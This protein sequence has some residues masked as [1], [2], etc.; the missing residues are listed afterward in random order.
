MFELSSRSP[1]ILVVD[2]FYSDPD[3]VRRDA[4]SREFAANN[5][6]YKGKRST[7]RLL[8]DTQK[9]EFERLLQRRITEWE[10]HSANGCFQVTN[11]DDPLVY[12]CDTQNCAAAIYLTPDAPVGAGTSFWRDRKY[13][14]RRGIDYDAET[15]REVW[16]DYNLL[17]AD[18][19]ELVDRVGAVFNRLVIWDARLIHSASSYETFGD[20]AAKSRLVQLFFFDIS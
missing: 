17:H 8:T 12:H 9:H 7:T 20:E 13:H 11:S 5:L 3:A 2:N 14:Y 4:L 1:S 18:N 15:A 10:S 19:W 6:Y 16:H